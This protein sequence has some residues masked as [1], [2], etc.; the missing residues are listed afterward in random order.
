MDK[1]HLAICYIVG[2]S[3][4]KNKTYCEWNRRK[5]ADALG[6]LDLLK[7]KF[8]FLMSCNS[9]RIEEIGAK[10]VLEYGKSNEIRSQSI[11]A[12]DMRGS[13]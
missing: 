12:R 13:D 5:N 1:I 4:N 2:T 8:R 7:C 10:N 9:K 3:T 11:P 6:N